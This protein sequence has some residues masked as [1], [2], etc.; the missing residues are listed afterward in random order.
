M[1]QT[2]H[3]LTVDQIRRYAAHLREQERAAATI[4]KYLHDLTALLS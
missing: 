2:A 1:N 3:T 4:R